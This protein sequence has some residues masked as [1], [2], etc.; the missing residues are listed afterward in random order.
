MGQTGRILLDFDKALCQL[1][2]ISRFFA[3]I[4]RTTESEVARVREVL[5]YEIRR[6]RTP[7]TMKHIWSPW[8][9]TY[10]QNHDEEGCVFCNVQAQADSPENLIV[11]RG[12]RA[13]VI[14]NR[15]PYTS[16]HLMVVP[17]DHQPSFEDLDAE[18]RAEVM[19]L[20]TRCIRVLR[21]VYQPEAFNVGANIGALAGAGVAE[22]VH[23]HI[24][25]RWGGDTNFMST[26]GQTRVLP[27]EL[28]ET[29]RRVR[30]GWGNE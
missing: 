19:E 22:H 29:Y 25:P 2:L 23:M 28:E 3:T 11:F 20:T 7:T 12:R 15:Y 13:F 1:F 17:T 18:T 9:M 16:G 27:E 4:Q 10:I 30:E 14:L 26:L 5:Q 6:F 21:K 24:V 8:R